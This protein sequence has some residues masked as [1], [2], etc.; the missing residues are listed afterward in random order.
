MLFGMILGFEGTL[1]LILECNVGLGYILG[2]TLVSDD[3]TSHTIE[4]G[5]ELGTYST[6]L[7]GLWAFNGRQKLMLRLLSVGGGEQQMLA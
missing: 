6:L 4:T 5:L 1:P 7:P 3:E 2:P